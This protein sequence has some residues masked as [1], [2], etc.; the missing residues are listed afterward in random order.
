M[1]ERRCLSEPYGEGDYEDYYDEDVGYSGGDPASAG[2]GRSEC[3]GT[4]CA[5]ASVVDP[6]P[7]P[8]ESEIFSGSESK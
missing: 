6:Y 1:L 4:L 5:F 8:K 7:N 2:K 3:L